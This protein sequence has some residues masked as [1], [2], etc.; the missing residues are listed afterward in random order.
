MA[1]IYMFRIWFWIR[2]VHDMINRAKCNRKTRHG[3]R[4]VEQHGIALESHPHP[5]PQSQSYVNTILGCIAAKIPLCPLARSVKL[6]MW[7]SWRWD[8]R[9]WWWWYLSS[10]S[11]CISK[12]SSS[13]VASTA[14]S[15]SRRLICRTP[16]SV[17]Y[18]YAGTHRESIRVS[19][20]ELWWEWRWGGDGDGDGDDVDGNWNPTLQTSAT[21]LCSPQWDG[22][23]IRDGYPS[24]ANAEWSHYLSTN[25]MNQFRQWWWWRWVLE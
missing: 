7:W 20:V 2:Y 10:A 23:D 13:V 11:F 9:W 15:I 1:T 19:I 8:R 4:S 6:Q 18:L 5:H 12:N 22:R 14:N 16:E 17:K 21:M 25:N 3:C 24:M